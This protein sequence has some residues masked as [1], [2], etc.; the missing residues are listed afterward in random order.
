MII[1][2]AGMA[3][4]LAGQLLIRHKPVIVEAKGEL[5]NNHSAVLRF[6]SNRVG[7]VLGIKFHQVTMMRT[8][9]PWR[10]VVADALQYAFKNTGTYRS[11]RTAAE[12]TVVEQ[13][14]IAPPDLI[15]LMSQGLSIL[16]GTPFTKSDL[17]LQV[18][19]IISTLPM[20]ILMELLEYPNSPEFL[21]KHGTNIRFHICCCDAYVSINIVDPNVPF[22]RITITS[23][24]VIVEL[25]GHMKDE[26]NGE[27]A[28][29]L[30]KMALHL[31]GMNESMLESTPTL[32]SQPY[33]KIEPIDEM[34]R[35]DFIYWATTKHGIYSLGRFATWRPK[36][37]L[38]DLIHDV[39]LIEDW[40]GSSKYDVAKHRQEKH[41]NPRR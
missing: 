13:R 33:A 35:K 10:N 3:G 37:L 36:L 14:W 9:L 32:H 41:D 27:D 25:P 4:L 1:I 18:E 8:T 29:D 17:N 12:G 39:R 11:D 34:V 23:N 24:E 40:I 38:D 26:F 2:G 6:R 22:S 30:T 15:R 20:P 28:E 7:E 19:P 21:Y 31:L 16:Y 5:P